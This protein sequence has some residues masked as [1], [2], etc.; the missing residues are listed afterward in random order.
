VERKRA[1]TSNLAVD[2]L[3]GQRRT[4]IDHDQTVVGRYCRAVREVGKK[5]DAIGDLG[6]M[7]ESAEGIRLLVEVLAAPAAIR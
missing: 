3:G 2:E 5:R 4:G 1:P 7:T 6:D